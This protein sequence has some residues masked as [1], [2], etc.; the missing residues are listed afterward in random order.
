M[1][2][3][4]NGSQGFVVAEQLK[5]AYMP[6]IF[7][8]AVHFQTWRKQNPRAR[9][10]KATCARGRSVRGIDH[11]GE[12][13]DDPG[14]KTMDTKVTGVTTRRQPPASELNAHFG[15]SPRET[16][17]APAVLTSPTPDPAR[18]GTATPKPDTASLLR[19]LIN[20]EKAQLTDI[21]RL[22]QIQADHI[23]TTREIWTTLNVIA[24][25]LETLAAAPQV[26]AP[27]AAMVASPATN[28]GSYEDVEMHAV[29]MTYDD[30]GQPAYK[31]TGGK[32]SKFGVRIWPEV[33]PLLNVDP[34]TLKPGPNPI[35]ATV[36][37]ALKLD[38]SDGTLKAQKVVGLAPAK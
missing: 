19:E 15:P 37:V 18:A 36:R 9:I 14:E 13:Y 34:A 6:H 12:I 5:G 38:E 8:S 35:T 26:A 4:F 28:G 31:M 20:V 24:G 33:L 2:G 1:N 27:A 3:T 17:P 7:G 30:K 29:I 16:T 21:E 10:V 11:R 23:A 22:V 32:Y 25:R